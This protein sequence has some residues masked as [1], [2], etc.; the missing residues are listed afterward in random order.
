MFTIEQI[1]EAHTRVRTGADF[2]SYIQDLKKIGVLSYEHYVS[3]GHIVY[4]GV[5]DFNLK[6]SPKWNAV[7]VAAKGQKE[8][9]EQG[10]KIHQA[11]KTDYLT[12]CRQSAEAGVEKWIVDLQNMM[13]TYYDRSDAEMVA[14]SIPDAIAYAQ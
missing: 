1:R 8:K 5:S 13:C 11:G 4:H 2:P 12:F 9:L 7:P 14:E 10:L 6:A 3:D